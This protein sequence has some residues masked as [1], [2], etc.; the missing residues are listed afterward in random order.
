VEGSLLREKPFFGAFWNTNIRVVRHYELYV[1]F[2]NRDGWRGCQWKNAEGGSL[3]LK[4]KGFLRK[5][6]SQNCVH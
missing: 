6:S 5:K 1:P 2:E 3:R 4:W